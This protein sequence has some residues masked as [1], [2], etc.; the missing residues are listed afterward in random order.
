MTR[1]DRV[2]WMLGKELARWIVSSVLGLCVTFWSTLLLV[3]ISPD[4]LEIP[5]RNFVRFFF[6]S[7]SLA[8]VFCYL[9]FAR[10]FPRN[11][12]ELPRRMR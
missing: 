1:A 3:L 11:A 8:T 9:V 2:A 6:F 10:R 4:L 7:T 12:D 5:V